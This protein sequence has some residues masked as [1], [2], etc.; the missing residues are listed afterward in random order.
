MKATHWSVIA[1]VAIILV[2]LSIMALASVS[3]QELSIAARLIVAAMGIVVVSCSA[4]WR[5]TIS[6]RMHKHYQSLGFAYVAYAACL[7]LGGIVL[8]PQIDQWQDLAAL[9]RTIHRDIG[10]NAFSLF[11]ADET[12]IAMMDHRLLTPFVLVDGGEQASQAV[13]SWFQANPAGRMLVRLPGHATGPLTEIADHVHRQASPGDDQLYGLEQANAARLIARYELPQG[14]R[15]ALI[16]AV[17]ADEAPKLTTVAHDLSSVGRTQSLAD[18]LGV[19]GD[20]H[21]P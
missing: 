6:H 3:H 18:P 5:A 16:G 1:F 11:Q 15:Y 4:L 10:N 20:R 2:A 8:F 19:V 21:L 17:G 14:R 12:T 7:T 9:A 13:R